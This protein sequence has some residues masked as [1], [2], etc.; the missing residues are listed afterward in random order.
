MKIAGIW[1]GHDCSY[2]VLKDGIPVVHDELERFKREKECNGDAFKLMESNYDEIDDIQH[3][4]TCYPV[5]KFT[6]HE[7]SFKKIKEIVEKNGGKIY[8]IPHHQA[9]AAN[10]FYSSNFKESIIITLDGGGVESQNFQTATTIWKGSDNKIDCIHKFHIHELN[11]GGLWTRVTRYVFNLQNGWPRGCQAG[12]VMAMAAFGDPSK[13]LEDFRR[14]LTVDQVSASLKPADQPF[15]ANVGTDPEHP[16]LHKYRL[17]ADSSEQEKFNLAASL[18]TATEELIK[19]IIGQVLEQFPSKNL[20][21]A[22]GVTLNCVAVGK[23]KK[24]FPDIENVYVTPTPHDGGLP[25]GA[26]QFVWHHELNN[27]RIDWSDNF[28]AYLGRTYTLD[29]VNDTI[30]NYQDVEVEEGVSVEKVV[31][32]LSEQNIVSV[33]GGGS[34]SGRRALGN[35]SILADPRSENMKDLIN[36]KVKHRQWYR[37]FAPSILREEVSEWFERDDDSPY[38]NVVMNFKE[39]KKSEVPAVVHKDGTARIQTVTEKD[40]NW[41]YNFLKKWKE[42]AGV[43][44]ILNTSFND[45][46]PICETPQHAI[47]CFLGTDIDFLYFYDYNILLRKT[48]TD[49]A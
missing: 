26:C 8:C 43:P 11:I 22:G 15:G 13:Y 39:D 18:Q 20:C 46:E 6:D 45:R 21:L 47:N 27:P 37:P 42:K 29:E 49:K 34:E 24:W 44:I 48:K 19:N 4:A 23:I 31:D 2:T 32:L 25:I 17:I 9:H 40:N 14:M 30:K 5:N 1:N 36:E 38:M 35:R 41:Y 28:K 7:D 12:S 3:F 10:A 16:Y 33:F